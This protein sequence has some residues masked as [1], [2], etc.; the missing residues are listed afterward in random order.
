MTLCKVIRHLVQR[1]CLAFGIH[2]QRVQKTYSIYRKLYQD[3]GRHKLMTAMFEHFQTK[4]PWCMFAV[5]A[6]S[7][8]WEEHSITNDE[9]A[10]HIEELNILESVQ[11]TATKSLP[12]NSEYTDLPDEWENILDGKNIKIWKLPLKNSDRTQYKVFGRFHDVSARQFFFVQTDLEYRR[13]WDKL[14]IDISV[15]DE[16][17]TTGEEVLRWIS[18]FPYPFKAREYVYIRRLKVLQSSNVMAILARSVDHP[19]C[20][21]NKNHVRVPLYISEMVI[22]PHKTIDEP[23]LDYLLTYCDD[24]Q[25]S[26]PTRVSSWVVTTGIPDYIEKLHKASLNLNKVKEDK[27]EI[28][29][30]MKA[31]TKYDTNVV[32]KNQPKHCMQQTY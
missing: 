21:T 8:S 3:Y 4:R 26:L 5:A 29:N 23:G 27:E 15:V 28:T 2:M 9:I 25:T 24:P 20:V 18:Y 14:V 32:D 13:K 11:S 16:N 12:S 19:K 1:K 10:R 31:R 6:C 17:Q 30:I 22:K 7:F